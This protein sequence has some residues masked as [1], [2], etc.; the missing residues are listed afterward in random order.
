[1]STKFKLDNPASFAY[2]SHKGVQSAIKQMLQYHQEGCRFVLEADIVDFFGKVDI[3][4]LLHKIIFPNLQD[5]TINTLIEAAFRMEVG[6]LEN[7]PEEDWDLYPES[8]SGLPQG[9]YLSPLFSNIYL[10]EFDQRMLEANFRLIRYADDFIV[11]CKTQEEAERAYDLSC[12]ILENELNLKLHERND[13][14]KEAKTRIVTVTQKPIQFLGIRFNGSRIWPSDEKRQNLRYKLDRISRDP[15]DILA[16]L[17]SIR[18]LLEG[19]VAAYGFTDLNTRYVESI[20]E[21]VNKYLWKALKKLQWKISQST[22]SIE[23]RANSGVKSAELYLANIRGN[24]N[25]KDRELLEKYW[26]N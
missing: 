17:T 4:N 25:E 18:N 2:L 24:M 19:W 5:T 12:K 16:L 10:S 11:M 14:K 8:S 7:L 22:L 1:L 20:D 23:Q 15:Q 9:G 13:T 21:E 3:N 6:N 26:T